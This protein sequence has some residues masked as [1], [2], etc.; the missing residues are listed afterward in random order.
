MALQDFA[1][2]QKDGQTDQ[3]GQEREGGEERA[4]RTS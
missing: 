1:L 4:G 3:A 2:Q